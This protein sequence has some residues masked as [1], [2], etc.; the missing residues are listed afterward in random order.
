MPSLG[1][2]MLAQV[3]RDRDIGVRVVYPILDFVA[4]AGQ[5][6]FDRVSNLFGKIMLGD[7]LFSRHFDPV[8]SV[9]EYLAMAAGYIGSSRVEELRLLIERLLP[10]VGRLIDEAADK[11]LAFEPRIVGFSSSF[12]Q[13]MSSL[14]LARRL[15][16]RRPDL[17]LV[18][19]GAN[20]SAPMGEALFDA[21][22]VLDGVV[23]G[24]GEIALPQ[25]VEAVL[26]GE[27]NIDLPGV[28]WRNPGEAGERRDPGIAPEPAMEDLPYPHYDDFF[29][30]W[31]RDG[32]REPMV[33]LEGS[34]GCWWGEKQH[35]VFCSLNHSIHY[36]SKSPA[37][38]LREILYL[39]ERYPGLQLFAMDDILD[40]RVIG[41][42]TDQLAALPSPPRLYYS[43]KS[44]IRKEQLQAL[45]RA[46]VNAVQPGIE[47]FADE[48]LTQMRKGVTGLRN[49][50]MLKWSGELDIR[51]SWSILYGFPFD[52]ADYYHRMAEWVPLLTHLGPP[53]GLTDVRIQRY[54]PLFTQ[55]KMFGVERLRPRPF[56]ALVYNLPA[57]SIGRLAYNFDWDPP[58][59]Q[60][61]YIDPLR[62]EVD[63]WI[64]AARSRRPMLAYRE[65]D[66]GGLVVRDTRP[67]AKQDEHRLG[68]TDRLICLA[69]DKVMKSH[70]IADA[71]AEAGCP[72]DP[73]TLETRLMRLRE[74]GLILFHDGFYLFLACK[75]R[76]NGSSPVRRP[77]VTGTPAPAA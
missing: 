27:K 12:Q 68:R 50:Q 6:D 15:R 59:D 3:L 64:L 48:V 19:G 34:R 45:A 70:Q 56:Y 49:V 11:I 32:G 31:P 23:V 22:P 36:R 77:A 28:H 26:G 43:L 30:V 5:P 39:H 69:C 17:K 61:P 29:E 65:L 42:I 40:L 10:L 47:S 71:L 21:C 20:C 41:T 52:R 73:A 75:E 58:E 76:E 57:A 44:N 35:C 51:T 16:E 67:V 1:L 2:S 60:T 46:G 25:L 14:A 13:Q 9:D 37:R 54:S 7:W 66:D 24:P 4:L 55:A 62:R 53:R 72:I 8:G 18:L 33:P 63:R 74:A 38:L